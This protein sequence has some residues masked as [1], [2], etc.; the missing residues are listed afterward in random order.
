MRI[1]VYLSFF[2]IFAILVLCGLTGTILF[3]YYGCCN[4]YLAGWISTSDQLMPHLVV[5]ILYDY[6]GAAGLFVAGAFSGPDQKT[7][8]NLNIIFYMYFY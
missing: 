3:A 1:A 8:K 6:P 4:P 2:G 7:K 5:N